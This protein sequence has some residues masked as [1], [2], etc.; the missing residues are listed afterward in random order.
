MGKIRQSKQANTLLAQ[1]SGELAEAGS[2]ADRR[3][4]LVADDVSLKLQ[5]TTVTEEMLKKYTVGTN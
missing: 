1:L 2:T 4:R 3:N 5:N